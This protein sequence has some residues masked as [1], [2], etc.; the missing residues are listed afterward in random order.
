[1]SILENGAQFWGGR[2]L[3]L[4]LNSGDRKW[5]MVLGWDGIGIEIKQWGRERGQNLGVGRY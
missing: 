4:K 1:M 3:T 2:V 5:G